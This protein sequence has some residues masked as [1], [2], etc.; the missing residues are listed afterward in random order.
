GDDCD[1]ADPAVN[2]GAVEIPGNGIDDNC[3][4]Q[5]DEGF[6]TQLKPAY[7]G[8]TLTSVGQAI[9][10]S[11]VPT[12][13]GYRFEVTDQS[14]MN[15]Q[16]IDRTV[17]NFQL[18]Q[19]PVYDYSATYSV[20]VEVK[21]G[22]MWVGYYGPACMVNTPDVAGA[23]GQAQISAAQ[24]G[25][26]IA[27]VST[28]IATTSLPGVST[29]RFRVTDLTDTDGPHG[30]QVIDRGLHWFSLTMLDRYNYGTTYQIEVAVKTALGVFTAYGQACT[31]TT[32]AVPEI[33]MC[34]AIVPHAT[35]KIPTTSLLGATS[36]R[37]EITN[38]QT[39]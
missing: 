23:G 5:I 38:T 29:Y 17:P 1:D 20:R 32:P 15:V 36:Y 22:G 33:S 12:A 28:L 16:T 3:D 26:Q 37:F 14:T 21:I 7:C 30:V 39:L 10:C 13:T 34:G 19:L 31:V 4:G 6:Y 24:C 11:S 9:G 8:A 2:P 35:T 25:Q 27:T 18:S